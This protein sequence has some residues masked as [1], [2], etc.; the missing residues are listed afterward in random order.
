MKNKQNIPII[1]CLSLP[2]S[3]AGVNLLVK[4]RVVFVNVASGLTPTHKQLPNQGQD[5][6]GTC[7]PLSSPSALPVLLQ[8]YSPVCMNSG[9]TS[10]LLY[11]VLNETVSMPHNQTAT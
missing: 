3:A 6:K 9:G 2:Q 5:I 8:L 7:W 11:H 1:S 10:W 4:V